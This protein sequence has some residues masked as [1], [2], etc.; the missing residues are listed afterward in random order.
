MLEILALILIGV[1]LGFDFLGC[2][3]LVRFPDVYN[4]LQAA[5]KCV[6]LGT[7]G[8]LF[9]LFM[10]NGFSAMGIKCLICAAFILLTSPTASHAIARGAYLSGLK[11]WKGS[12]CDKLGED[13]KGK[14]QIEGK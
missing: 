9:G 14:P 7:S 4:R 1:G 3:G 2:L 8:I 5:T 11:L 13:K 10:L 6:T 12:V